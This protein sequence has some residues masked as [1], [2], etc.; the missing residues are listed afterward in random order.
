MISALPQGKE[1]PVPTEE[2]AVR[3]SQCGEGE[4]QK[5]LY[6]RWKLKPI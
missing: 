3:E 4:K 6:P 2:D 5:N 1:S